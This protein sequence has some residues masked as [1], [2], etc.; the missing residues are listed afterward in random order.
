MVA[1]WLFRAFDGLWGPPLFQFFGHLL[2][3]VSPLTETEINAASSV[4]GPGSIRY[5]AVRV[6][7]GR[8][9]R[10]VFRLNK[11]R[12]F[13]TFHT[14]NLRWTPKFGQVAKRESRF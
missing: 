13:T 5:G 1:K 11:G 8:L 4:L 9:L 2:T 7:E 3:R 6:A 12:A 14:I 10:P